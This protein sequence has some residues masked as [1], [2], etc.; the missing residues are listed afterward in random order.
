MYF[1]SFESFTAATTN[2]KTFHI[3]VEKVG[4]G[5]DTSST[6][7]IA[8]LEDALEEISAIEGGGPAHLWKSNA[9]E[10][11]IIPH[12]QVKSVRLIFQ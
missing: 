5:A 2:S 9:K 7:P 1:T 4:G 6:I 10:L 11:I 3:E 8:G 12:A